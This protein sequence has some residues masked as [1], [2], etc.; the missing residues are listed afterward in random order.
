M[1]PSITAVFRF[2]FHFLLGCVLTCS[3]DVVGWAAI[4][5]KT[6]KAF[7]R[8]KDT[9][10]E[11][12]PPMT[13]TEAVAAW[14]TPSGFQVNLFSSSPTI[15]QPI[16]GTF[17]RFGRLW[18]AENYTYAELPQRFDRSLRDRVVILEDSN[19]DGSADRHSV[20]NDQVEMLAS[21]EVGMGGVWLL[22]APQL[23]FIPDRDLDGSPDGETQV[24][25]DGFE[26]RDVGHNLVNGLRWGPD[27]WLYGR[28]GIQATSHVGKPG[29]PPE[30]RITLNCCIWRYH[31]TYEKFEVVT[32]GTTNPWGHDWDEHGELFFI[33]TVIGHLWHAIPGLHTERMYG[34]DLRPYLFHL[35]AQVADHYHWDRQFEAW[36][37]QRDG[38]TA[39]TDAA[40][41]GHAHSGL[42]M[43][44][45]Y[46]WPK[47]YHGDVLTLNFHGRRINQDKLKPL[48]A[49]YTAEHCPDPFKTTDP[50]FRGIDLFC[51]PDDAMYV[52]DWSDLGECHENDG[53]HR[54]SG[55]VYRVD[56]AANS[57]AT[58]PT[59]VRSVTEVVATLNG[60]NLSEIAKLLHDQRPWVW[61]QAR[62]R[63]QEHAS[64]FGR[65]DAELAN[66]LRLAK[67]ELQAEFTA[68]GSSSL[69]H[70]LLTGLWATGLLTV[71]EITTLLT[72]SD[73]HVRVW[74]IRFLTDS[75]VAG[76]RQ[77]MAGLELGTL[78]ADTTAALLKLAAGE[79][80]GLVLT[81][82]ASSMRLMSAPD[83]WSLAS[84]LVQH[85][86]FDKDRVFPYLV[87]YGLEP[88]VAFHSRQVAEILTTSRLQVIDQFIA[89]RLAIEYTLRPDALQGVIDFLSDKAINVAKKNHLLDGLAEGWN[90]WSDLPKPTGWDAIAQLAANNDQTASLL[91]DL[92]TVF[93]NRQSLS[94]RLAL[95]ND[96]KQTL[97]LRG[98]LI[99]S[100]VRD[101]ERAGDTWS[102]TDEQ[103]AVLLGNLLAHRFLSVG[104]A[105]GLALWRDSRA[106]DILIRKYSSAP[107]SGQ[108]AIVSALCERADRARA[109]LSAIQTGAIPKAAI[110][111]NQIRQLQLLGQDEIGTLIAKIWPELTSLLGQ[112]QMQQIQALR[113]TL[114]TEAIANADMNRGQQLFQQQCGKC[115]RLFGAGETL[116]PELTGAQ[117]DNLSYWL[118]NVVAPS[119]EVNTEFRLSLI[120]MS[121]GRTLSGVVTQ[122]TPT[123]FVLVS[124]EQ[125]QLIKQED[126]EE[127]KALSQSL[128][129]DGLLDALSDSDKQALFKYLM[130]PSGK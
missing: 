36:M 61:R 83:R 33:N 35:T 113:E 102:E 12:A 112:S 64:G 55:R 96:E 39:G 86:E 91:G 25:L 46:R 107:A 81:Y 58:A 109:L 40:G 84:H 103:A 114:S 52:L 23:L 93:E 124:Q 1:R 74:A 78:S 41:G 24:I 3:A 117:R 27:G 69:R 100:V 8:G 85:G 92:N 111:A 105:Q 29:T 108:V 56:Y 127:I 49:T 126:V 37:Q 63:I 106:T 87:W 60:S 30:N 38:M 51:G 43:Y 66:D 70:R 31:P 101:L 59:A 76:P 65:Q 97:E 54:S 47:E 80:H 48:G 129:P 77:R 94:D 73:P 79:Q 32:Q 14:T 122:K 130:S 119:A 53:I 2:R 68:A 50:W 45:G 95:L 44:Q 67:A 116:G 19:Q 128:M 88:S 62:L 18:L 15:A 71:E 11:T 17:D 115:H 82:L 5:D 123:S 125:S 28:H 118:Q 75:S 57:T 90:G 22:C 34:E 110:S 7:D 89:R 42:A 99:R 6:S 16:A 20:F 21:V 4:Q 13:D 120:Q 26:D 104:A 10:A 9:Q 72:H 121:D 98:S